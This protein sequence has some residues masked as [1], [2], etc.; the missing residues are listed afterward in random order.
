[1][2][3][4]EDRLQFLLIVAAA[5]SDATSMSEEKAQPSKPAT[6]TREL[7]E[8]S[9]LKLERA[10]LKMQNYQLQI[11]ALQQAYSA[12]NSDALTAIEEAYSSAKLKKEEWDLDPNNFVFV[13]KKK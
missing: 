7:P 4:C 6:E 9:R 8:I 11:Q 13:R 5:A 3:E 10:L 1:M 12:A 2:Y